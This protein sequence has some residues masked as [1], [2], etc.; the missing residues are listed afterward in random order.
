[1]D[2]LPDKNNVT[3]VNYIYH[4]WFGPRMLFCYS[5]TFADYLNQSL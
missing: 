2:K 3:T 4:V 1:M 5:K